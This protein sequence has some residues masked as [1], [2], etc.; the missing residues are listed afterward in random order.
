MFTKCLRDVHKDVTM[1]LQGC[2]RKAVT[3]F[4]QGLH[5]E[6]MRLFYMAS[7]M[8]LCKA[9]RRPCA[10]FVRI[11]FFLYKDSTMLLKCIYKVFTRVLQCV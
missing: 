9:F 7:T 1:C 6:L 11:L 3:G 4:S 2:F 8:R 5:K 10:A